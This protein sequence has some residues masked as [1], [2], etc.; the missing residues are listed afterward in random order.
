MKALPSLIA[1]AIVLSAACYAQRCPNPK[2]QLP[3]IGGDTIN[4][5]VSLQRK[6]LKS[7]QDLLFSG[8]LVVPSGWSATC[9]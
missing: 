7:A 5:Y 9:P 4:G 2:M 3:A 8:K 1:I 6:P